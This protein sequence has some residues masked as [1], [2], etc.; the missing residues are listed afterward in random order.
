M[1]RNR[2]SVIKEKMEKSP[3]DISSL[4]GIEM[5][6]KIKNGSGRIIDKMESRNTAVFSF[7]LIEVTT[8]YM[9]KRS[10]VIPIIV[11]SVKTVSIHNV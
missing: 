3:I 7:S 9:K 11:L 2:I 8:P 5:N 6:E 10:K 4:K 1:G